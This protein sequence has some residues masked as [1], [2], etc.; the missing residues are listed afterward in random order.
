M[1]QCSNKR[2]V[3]NIKNIENSNFLKIPAPANDRS[4]NFVTCKKMHSQ[5]GNVKI[6][7]LILSSQMVIEETRPCMYI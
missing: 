5:L 6:Q 1:G 2:G 4:V 7:T 3:V